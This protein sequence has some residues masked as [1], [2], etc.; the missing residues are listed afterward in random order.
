PLHRVAV[1]DRA[2]GREEEG[3]EAVDEREPYDE[4][5]ERILRQASGVF[6]EK[7]YDRAS[8]RDIAAATD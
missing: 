7:G 4:K 8:I 6:A 3:E 1:T 5:L 2:G